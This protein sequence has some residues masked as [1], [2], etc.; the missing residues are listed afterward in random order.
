MPGGR[1]PKPP[2]ERTVKVSVHPDI[3]THGRLVGQVEVLRAKGVDASLSGLAVELI[4]EG[5]DRRT[6]EKPSASRTAR[7]ARA[8]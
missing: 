2:E 7:A 6:Q 4:R 3:A 1:P 8:R 5:L